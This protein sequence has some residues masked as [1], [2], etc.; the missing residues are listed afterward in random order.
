MAKHFGIHQLELKSGV[1]EE[2]FEDFLK[3]LASLGHAPGYTFHHL[4]G[5]KGDRKGLY[6]ILVEVEN[7]EAWN[8]YYKPDGE[9]LEAAKLFWKAHP[10]NKK[11][12][13]KL[14]ILS[15][16]WGVTFNDYVELD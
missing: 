10:E 9:E 1:T 6:L 3:E 5:I 13:E 16:G 4:K 2:E 15:D 7:A 11:W 14:D 12:F 8:R